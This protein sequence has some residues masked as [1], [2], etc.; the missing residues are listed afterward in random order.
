[1]KITSLNF[2]NAIAFGDKVLNEENRKNVENLRLKF[3]SLKN[4]GIPVGDC[5]YRMPEG[6]NANLSTA[7]KKYRAGLS[8]WG[9]NLIISEKLPSYNMKLAVV[10]PDGNVLYSD[11]IDDLEP[12]NV[13]ANSQ[14]EKEANDFLS[15][16]LP[17]F[18]K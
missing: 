15:E 1:M 4:D 8:S 9:D 3:D 12:E 2:S 10:E 14:K 16:V 7:D 17:K 11:S 5:F 6:H 18:L 13:E